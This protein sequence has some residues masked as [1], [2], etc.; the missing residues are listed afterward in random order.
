M[1]H[2]VQTERQTKAYMIYKQDASV[3]IVILPTL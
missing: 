1:A 2:F 3:L